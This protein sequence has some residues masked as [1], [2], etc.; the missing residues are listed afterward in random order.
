[1]ANFQL[2]QFTIKQ[3]DSGMKVC[4]DSLLFAASIDITGVKNILDI[5]AGTGI[6]SLILAQK[7]TELSKNT[8][9]SI[10]AVELTPEAAAE[11]R[12][13][14]SQSP[15][16]DRLNVEEMS[17]QQYSNT[18]RQY[19]LII[20][21]PPFFDQHSRTQTSKQLRGIARHTDT[22]PFQELLAAISQLLTP[23]GVVHL[24]LPISARSK[25]DQ[26][27]KT[28]ALVIVDETHVAESESHAVKTIY[29]QLAFK[30]NK[31]LKNITIN[32]LIKFDAN[33]EHTQAVRQYLSPYLLRYM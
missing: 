28:F 31:K 8:V 11:A 10:T 22:L 9:E 7:S 14:F 5:G 20:C 19:D 27:L 23:R 32:K 16:A 3:S 15:W 26:L 1:M 17:I 25:V 6:L 18:S 4:S 29:L 33:K 21:N 12:F 13:N 30:A 24:L 2:Q